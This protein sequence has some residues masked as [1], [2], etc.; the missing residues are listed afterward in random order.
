MI[1]ENIDDGDLVI[2]RN[3]S[4]ADNGQKVVALINNSEITLKNLSTKNRIRL[5]PA[6]PELKSF[7]IHARDLMIQGI[8]ID[9]IKILKL[10][11]QR[12]QRFQHTRS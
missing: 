5:Q 4:T 9:V 3:Q 7:Y 2:V 11:L 8:V 12:K 6:N 1:D 10:R